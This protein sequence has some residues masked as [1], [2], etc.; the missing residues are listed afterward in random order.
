MVL[1][2]F[3][4][5]WSKTSFHNYYFLPSSRST[6]PRMWLPSNLHCVPFL[7]IDGQEH[8]QTS[9]PLQ[10]KIVSRSWLGFPGHPQWGGSS[11]TA[12]LFQLSPCARL[13]PVN[14]AGGGSFLTAHRVWDNALKSNWKDSLSVFTRH[15]RRPLC[16]T[17]PKRRCRGLQSVCGLPRQNPWELHSHH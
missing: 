13:T 10:K 1:S 16:A 5:S 14:Q 3:S 4:G 17:F 9:W 12:S 2:A 15:C 6:Q 7:W 8:K 11:L